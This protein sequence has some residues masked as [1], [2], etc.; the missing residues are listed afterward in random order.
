MGGCSRGATIPCLATAE[1]SSESPTGSSWFM[2]I[3]RYSQ[4]SLSNTAA[5]SGHRPLN[6]AGLKLFFLRRCQKCVRFR[7]RP[8]FPGRARREH[9]AIAEEHQ[10]EDGH[11]S[12][13]HFEGD[14]DRMVGSPSHRQVQK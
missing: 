10:L 13:D 1:L 5:S 3:T 11:A 12:N 2:T 9:P 8:T 14:L 6:G 4:N 7:N